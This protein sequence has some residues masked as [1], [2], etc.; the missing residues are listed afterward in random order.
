M[1]VVYLVVLAVFAW[2]HHAH[3]NQLHPWTIWFAVLVLAAI[4]DL[5]L[6]RRA[7]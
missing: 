7:F 6:H 1:T 4:V 2:D 5:V 3:W